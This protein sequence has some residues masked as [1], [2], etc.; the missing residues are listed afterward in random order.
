MN[1]SSELSPIFEPAGAVFDG[2]SNRKVRGPMMAPPGR[3]KRS[4]T[5]LLPAGA[6]FNDRIGRYLLRCISPLM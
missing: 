2:D 6:D 5:R 3:D 4:W 1:W